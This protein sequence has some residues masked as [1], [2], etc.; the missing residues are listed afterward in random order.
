[1]KEHWDVF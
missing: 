1:M